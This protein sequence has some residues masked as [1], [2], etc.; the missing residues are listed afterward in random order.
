VPCV[1]GG[2]SWYSGFGFTIDPRT[3]EEFKRILIG[4]DKLPRLNKEQTD[5]AKLIALFCFDIIGYTNFPDPFR[6]VPTYDA[7]EQSSF[8]CEQLF[9]RIIEYRLKSSAAEKN[10]YIESIKEFIFNPNYEQFLNL[11]KYKIFQEAI[12]QGIEKKPVEI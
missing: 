4:I 1:L 10:K 3:D 6:T 9:A 7:E 11:E 8:S 2:Q 5:M 12:S